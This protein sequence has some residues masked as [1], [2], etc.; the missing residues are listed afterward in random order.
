MLSLTQMCQL[1]GVSRRTLQGYNTMGLLKHRGT[2]P[3]G[4][5]LYDESDMDRLQIIQLL[6]R[7]SFTRKDILSILPEQDLPLEDV[8]AGLRASLL[9]RREQLDLLLNLLDPVRFQQIAVLPVSDAGA[10]S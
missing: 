2:T 5:W 3:G 6:R 8:L 4:Y 9:E 1:T 10:S 7:F